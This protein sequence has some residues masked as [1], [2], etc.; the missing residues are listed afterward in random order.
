MATYAKPALDPQ[1]F[2]KLIQRL[3]QDEQERRR[4]I[5]IVQKD[6]VLAFGDEYF[7]LTDKQRDMLVE[8]TSDP[9]QAFRWK[10]LVSQGLADGI[11]IS[12]IPVKT[13]SSIDIGI[14]TEDVDIDIHIECPI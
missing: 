6:G 3:R 10:A 9:A 7:A 8:V 14:H 13:E 1:T 11:P 2:E 4:A 5:G 12:I